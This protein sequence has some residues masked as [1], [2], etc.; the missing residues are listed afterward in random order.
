MVDYLRSIFL[1]GEGT[2]AARAA[3]YGYA[4][5]ERV[6]LRDAAE[7]PQARLTLKGFRR[8]RPG[9]SGTPARGRQRY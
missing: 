8:R 4:F 6:S 2:F 9:S 7:F 5:E 3:V 1:A